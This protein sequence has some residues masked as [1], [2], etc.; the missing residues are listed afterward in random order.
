MK[1]IKITKIIIDRVERIEVEPATDHEEELGFS[2]RYMTITDKN[3]E[4]YEIVLEA[5]SR[6][7]LEMAEKP[8]DD[9]LTPK[10]Y[11]GSSSLEE[12]L[13]KEA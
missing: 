1:T 5:S 4:V 7:N 11:K 6:K 13:D 10:V 12:A 8:A 2:D 3:G 9:W